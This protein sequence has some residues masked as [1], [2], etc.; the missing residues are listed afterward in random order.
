[1]Q[2]TI[3]SGFAAIMEFSAVANANNLPYYNGGP[4]NTF[5]CFLLGIDFPF[6]VHTKDSSPRAAL[7][8]QFFFETGA[9]ATPTKTQNPTV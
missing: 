8:T 7:N 3:F 9:M 6:M 2:S 4:S 1:M 5:Y